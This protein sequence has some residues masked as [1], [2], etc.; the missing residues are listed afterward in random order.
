[1]NPLNL[2]R[3]LFTFAL[4]GENKMNNTER[5]LLERIKDMVEA[6]TRAKISE[7]LER[8][9]NDPKKKKLYNLTGKM[10]LRELIRQTDL[11][12]GTISHLWQK[13][14]SKGILKKKGKFYTKVFEEE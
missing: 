7:V 11:S 14:H 2:A 4:K 1:M 8:E 3:R 13:W 5:K 9:L 10:K 6:L 12:A